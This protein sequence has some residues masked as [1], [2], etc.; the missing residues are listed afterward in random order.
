MWEMGMV[1]KFEIKEILSGNPGNP[2]NKGY[3][4]CGAVH[5]GAP[6]ALVQRGARVFKNSKSVRQF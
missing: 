6:A 1:L 4:L 3:V 5:H 2:Y